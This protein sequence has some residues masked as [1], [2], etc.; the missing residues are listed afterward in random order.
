MAISQ[1]STFCLQ[2]CYSPSRKDGPSFFAIDSQILIVFLRAWERGLSTS[3]YR[4]HNPW[5][6]G[7][8]YMSSGDVCLRGY[9]KWYA[10]SVVLTHTAVWHGRQNL[11][12]RSRVHPQTGAFFN[13]KWVYQSK[14]W[15]FFSLK[16]SVYFNLFCC[17]FCGVFII[18]L[19]F[20]LSVFLFVSCLKVPALNTSSSQSLYGLQTTTLF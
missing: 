5:V 16:F 6:K 9:S 19:G 8:T 4:F 3:S 7:D 14:P 15:L 13:I 20:C 2:L 1:S 12:R 10:L 18:F 11:L 17:W